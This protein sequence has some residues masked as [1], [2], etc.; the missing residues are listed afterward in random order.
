MSFLCFLFK[1]GRD[2]GNMNATGGSF[3]LEDITRFMDFKIFEFALESKGVISS[4][5]WTPLFKNKHIPY[6]VHYY[7]SAISMSFLYLLFK[8]G[9]DKGNMKATGTSLTSRT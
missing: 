1:S 9:T 7:I 5:L 3:D 2:K 8:S 4:S 6:K